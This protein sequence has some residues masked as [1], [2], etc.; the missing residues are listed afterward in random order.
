MRPLTRCDDCAK[1]TRL[2]P[3][4][5]MPPGRILSNL[6]NENLQG[7]N[8]IPLEAG[9][10]PRILRLARELAIR[11]ETFSKGWRAREGSFACAR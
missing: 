4:L 11:R 8:A 2:R 7:V 1:R 9:A 6:A 5:E 3:F 10:L